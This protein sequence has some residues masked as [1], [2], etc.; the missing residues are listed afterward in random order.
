MALTSEIVI[1]IDVRAERLLDARAARRLVALELADVD[2]PASSSDFEPALFYRVLGR[3]GQSVRVELWERGEFHDARVVSALEGSGQLVARRVALAA[4]ELARDLRQRRIAER[5]REER[6]RKL[7]H[8]RDRIAAQRTREGPLALRSTFAFV[9]SSDL[10][11]GASSLTGE[12]SLRSRIR[13]DLGAR[14]MLGEDDAGR[15]RFT[16][17]ELTLGPSRRFHLSPALE[18]DLSAFAAPAIVHVGGARAVD[19]VPSVRQTWSA[20]AGTALR[21]QPRL[22]R[23]LRASFGLDASLALRSVAAQFP[24]GAEERYRGF[25][26][27]AEL[28]LVMTPP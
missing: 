28:G 2:V 12:I 16:W 10:T 14:L 3:A 6:E 26:F 15:A 13:L 18:L 11:L 27:G 21:L 5:R 22:T 25:F 20:R 8:E 7:Q 24:G 17:M 23:T 1:E 4:A 9:R 19:A